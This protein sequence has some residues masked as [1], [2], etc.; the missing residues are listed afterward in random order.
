[1]NMVHQCPNN[2]NATLIKL[3]HEITRQKYRTKIT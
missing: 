2:V 1:M 3:K